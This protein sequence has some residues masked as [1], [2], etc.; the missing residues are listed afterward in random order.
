[1]SGIRV[2]YTGLIS[3]SVGI[4]AIITSSIF[5][6]LI[7]R[8]LLPEEYGE[9]GVISGVIVY[10]VFI[11]AITSF[12]TTRE[13]SRGRY[14]GKT[15]MM[16]TSLL[17]IVAVFAYLFISYFLGYLTE[18]KI[19]HLLLASL[20][21]PTSLFV[22]ALQAI[23][24]GKRPHTI[25]YGNLAFGISQIPNGL[26]F[27]YLLDMSIT[28][29]ILSVII[30]HIV[31]IIVLLI[32]AKDYISGTFQ[33]NTLKKWFKISWIPLYPSIAIF[34]DSGFQITIFTIIT[35][36][37]LGIAYWSASIMIVSIISLSS[38]MS[39]G[40]YPKLL[41]GNNR[42]FVQSNLTH[43]FFVGILFTTIAISLGKPALFILNPVYVDAYFLVVIL[44][45]GSFFV[46]MR[47]IF[48][49]MLTAIETVDLNEKSTKKDYLKSKLFT[50]HTAQ[51]IA[52]AIVAISL[53]I[54]LIVLTETNTSVINYLEYW[55]FV[56]LVVEIS[57]SFYLYIHVKQN[58]DLKFETF[59]ILKYIL[60]SVGIFGSL[61]YVAETVLN[62]Q[63]G[64][65]DFVAILLV[66]ASMGI[67][68]YIFINYLIDYRSRELINSIIIELKNTLK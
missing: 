66:I 58:F 46:V 34:L 17:S 61:Y 23:N 64:I 13:I 67:T 1:L 52:T 60:V 9:W 41:E 5:T 6:V 44:S 59:S 12:W 16:G 45:I 35:G 10:V 24:L 14:V 51:N 57:L 22:G 27:V 49:Q 29:V 2:T 15:Q 3:L 63:F 37:L 26:I 39:T 47:N 7:T 25:S 43:L 30:S 50:V 48:K 18:V 19:E 32:F 33:Y 65:F 36:S 8:K 20:L 28:G 62:Y 38:L 4:T 21:I 40:I 54:G 56:V 68:A 53:V 11:G 31:N 55:A 42:S